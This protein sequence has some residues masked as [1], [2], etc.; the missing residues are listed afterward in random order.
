MRLS[1]EPREVVFRV[2]VIEVGLAIVLV[3]AVQ[4]GNSPTAS[5]PIVA[6]QPVTG[7]ALAARAEP[8]L[9][10]TAP[11]ASRPTATIEVA[12][13]LKIRMQNP[14]FS[15]NCRACEG[16]QETVPNTNTQH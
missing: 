16:F 3:P 2:M 10:A 6:L 5:A 13:F 4:F 14:L 7:W 8:P 1:S 15:F 9:P 11:K 12:A